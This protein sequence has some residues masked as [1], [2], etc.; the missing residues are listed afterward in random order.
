MTVSVSANSCRSQ[1]AAEIS[2]ER[3]FAPPVRSSGVDGHAGMAELA[4][5]DVGSLSALLA[6]ELGTYYKG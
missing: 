5:S 3:P 4:N 6:E 1:V 2:R